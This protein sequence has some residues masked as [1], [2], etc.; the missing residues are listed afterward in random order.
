MSP[1]KNS[2]QFLF[3]T[4]LIVSLL[5]QLEL[6]AQSKKLSFTVGADITNRYIWR[7]LNLGGNAL[8]LQPT[9]EVGFGNSGISLG[10]WGALTLTLAMFSGGAGIP[11]VIMPIVFGSAVTVTALASMWLNRDQLE[12][13]PWLWIG[14]AGMFVCILVVAY[15]TPHPASPKPPSQISAP[16]KDS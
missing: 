13:S 2:I 11:Q 3:V 1:L 5:T 7:G 9:V 8:S 15:N 10:A 12:T 4:F 16:P 6:N 14:V